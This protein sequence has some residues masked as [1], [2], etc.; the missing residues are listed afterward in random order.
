MIKEYQISKEDLVKYLEL[1]LSSRDIEKITGIKYGEI[2]YYIRQYGIQK[3]NRFCDVEYNESFFDKITT[4]ESAYVLGFFLGDG[5]IT[6]ENKFNISIAKSD[7]CVLEYISSVLGGRVTIYDK[8]NPKLRLFPSAGMHIGNKKIV[9]SL[10]MLFGGRLKSER[11]I[12]IIKKSLEP[13][14]LQG[15][16]DAKGCISFGYRKDRNRL[17]YKLT[18]TSQYKMLEGIQNILLN[19]NISS[20]LRKK[21]YENCFELA[22]PCKDILKTLDFVYSDKSFIILDRKFKKAEALRLELGEFGESHDGGQYRAKPT[23]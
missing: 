3:L 9:T 5:C 15:F 22:I 10:K 14:L 7:I 16:F 18:F 1:G 20:K 13:F 6:N 11:H 23:E 4:K 2:L 21:G 8:C 19:N 12:P 17:W